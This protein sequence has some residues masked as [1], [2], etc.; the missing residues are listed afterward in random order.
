VVIVAEEQQQARLVFTDVLGR[1]VHT[2]EVLLQK[3]ANRQE[4][5]LDGRYRPGIYQ[6][7]TY[8]G[9]RTHR[10]RLVKHQ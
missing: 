1:L 5:L 9:D 4:I 10:T 6:L 3:G 2:Q 8:V 7:T